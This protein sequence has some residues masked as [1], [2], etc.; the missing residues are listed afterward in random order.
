MTEDATVSRVD[1]VS[2]RCQPQP[3]DG[4]PMFASWAYVVRKRRAPSNILCL[5]SEINQRNTRD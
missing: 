4:C 3:L 5:L 2:S 1:E